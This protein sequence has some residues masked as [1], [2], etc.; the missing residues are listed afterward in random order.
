M[1]PNA[2]SLAWVVDGVVPVLAGLVLLVPLV[3]A[4]WSTGLLVNT[5]RYSATTAAAA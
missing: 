1:P 4:T 2:R 5:P 3:P